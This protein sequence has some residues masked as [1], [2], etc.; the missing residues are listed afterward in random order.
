MKGLIKKKPASF[1]EI[2]MRCISFPFSIGSLFYTLV[3]SPAFVSGRLYDFQT[4]DFFC[5]LSSSVLSSCGVVPG[6][7]PAM[8][9]AGL[10]EGLVFGSAVMAELS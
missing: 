7:C 4:P 3:D 9:T 5:H 1:L 2:E 10:G 6:R 8:Q